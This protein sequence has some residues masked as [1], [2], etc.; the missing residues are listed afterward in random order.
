MK[1]ETSSPIQLS[2]V[3][4]CPENWEAMLPLEQGRFCGSCRIEVVDFTRMS[5]EEMA[6][7]FLHPP[8]SSVCGRFYA[9]QLGRDL[10]SSKRRL[11]WL[12]YFFR[13]ALP[14]F[15]LSVRATAQG[16]VAAFCRARN[17]VDEGKTALNQVSAK[18]PEQ[19]VLL[20]DTIL[21]YQHVDQDNSER[22][23]TENKMAAGLALPKPSPLSQPTKLRN[24][25]VELSSARIDVF[26]NPA[27]SGEPLHLSFHRY[28]AGYHQMRL[29]NL[30]GQPVLNRKVWV[31][32]GDSLLSID[33]PAISAGIYWLQLSSKERQEAESVRLVIQY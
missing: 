22:K 11:P 4:P 29:V 8:A 9:D 6:A 20:G 33:L 2:V 16:K 14:A 32:E 28:P 17:P 12:R 15:F 24:A 30:S 3:E 18:L 19:R 27:W 21:P 13:L 7:F 23:R 5:D 31:D 25:P 1:S 26:P 10:R